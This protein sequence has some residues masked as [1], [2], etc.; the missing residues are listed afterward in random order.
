MKLQNQTIM[1]DMY[2]VRP[3]IVYSL[4]QSTT[5]Y[6]CGKGLDSGCAIRAKTLD[7]G[8]VLL[9]DVHYD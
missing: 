1:Q 7:H 2:V 8:I 4:A 3:R 9:C 5:C 6:V